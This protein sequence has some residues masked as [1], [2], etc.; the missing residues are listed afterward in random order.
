MHARM[1]VCT[2]T[3]THT[4]KHTH[5]LQTLTLKSTWKFLDQAGA[6]KGNKTVLTVTS[7]EREAVPTKWLSVS[8]SSEMY[9]FIYFDIILII[10]STGL[11]ERW[12]LIPSKKIPK[13]SQQKWNTLPWKN[14][15]QSKIYCIYLQISGLFFS[16]KNT[17]I[18]LITQRK[19]YAVDT[20]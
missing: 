6:Q 13:Y 11:I 20:N 5:S 18:F 10:G 4:H 9:V 2:H 12:G 3:H 14:T 15:E 16:L 7:P 17:D 8:C 1:Y 19:H